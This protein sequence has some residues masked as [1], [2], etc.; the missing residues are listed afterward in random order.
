MVIQRPFDEIVDFITSA[1][2][3]IQI[4]NFRPSEKSQLRVD[5]YWTKTVMEL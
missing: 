5:F 1:P 2:Q 4:L 3:P